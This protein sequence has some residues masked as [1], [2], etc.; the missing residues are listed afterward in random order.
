MQ[1]K[2]YRYKL[3]NNIILITPLAIL[4]FAEFI[5]HF[6]D[7]LSSL[8]KFFVWILMIAI[9]IMHNKY[10]RN[11]LFIISLFLVVLLINIPNTFNLN[12]AIEELIR[13][14]FLPVVLMFGY[15]F[16]KKID[17]IISLIIFMAF[18]SDI[19]QVY[20]YIHGFLG[21]G[22][23]I[24]DLRVKDGG[25]F[26]NTSFIGISNAILNFSAYMMTLVFKDIKYRNFLLIFFFIFT[27]LTFSYKTIPF[28][29]LSIFLF[30]KVSIKNYVFIGIGFFASG[31]YLFE[32]IIDMYSVLLRKIDVYIAIGN[33]ARY[34][35]YRVMFEFLSEFKL[36]GE[37]IG[38]FGGPS[39]I[40]YNSPIYDKYN[41]N[42]FY[43]TTI[44]TTDTYY[45]HLFVELGWLGG[46][47]FLALLFL[48]IFKTKSKRAK[49]LNLFILSAFLFECLFSFGLNNMLELICTVMLFYGINY[50]YERME[51]AKNTIN[52]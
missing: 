8:L 34:E 23:D 36:L 3:S 21:I 26:L 4:F 45:P 32:Y 12:A 7:S 39:S 22:P 11:L 15:V 52:K 48:P 28:L 29:L 47:I 30:N 51:Y 13:F 49:K 37:S 2:I 42:W 50:K 14:L 41:F 9:I 27:L 25:Y 35:S 16:R 20:L 6:T 40:I 19:F 43:T 17:L 24:I 1:S 46:I 31:F 10:S 33:S 5:K 38:S 44:A 18:I